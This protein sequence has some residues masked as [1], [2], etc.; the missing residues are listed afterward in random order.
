M[1]DPLLEGGT[2]DDSFLSEDPDKK[3]YLN[4]YAEHIAYLETIQIKPNK[5][6]KKP[7]RIIEGFNF[8]KNMEKLD[9]DKGLDTERL[10][11][12]NKGQIFWLNGEEV[13]FTKCSTIWMLN[14]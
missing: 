2:F 7:E 5:T 8:L 1:Y 12:K 3:I 14:N 13:K 9:R 10:R 4:S 6:R 11:F